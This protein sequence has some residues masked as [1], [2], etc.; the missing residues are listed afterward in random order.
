M[1]AV[2][3][4]GELLAGLARDVQ[5]LIRGEIALGRAELD[6]KLQRMMRS[7]VWLL[8]GALLGFSGLVVLLEGVAGILA[9]T[10]VIPPWAAALIVGV[11][12][13][14]LG[15]AFAYSG[16]AAMS[17]KKLAPERTV[18]NLQKDVQVIKEHG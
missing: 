12:I 18:T 10:L 14:A 2:P 15:A 7:A 11:V 4:I 8:G 16:L 9:S 3:S 5:Q 17:L 6:E 13:M 1:E